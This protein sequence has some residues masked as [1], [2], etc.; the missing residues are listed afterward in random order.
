MDKGEKGV[1]QEELYNKLFKA[2]AH[3]LYKYLYYK[4]GEDNNPHDIVQEAF[5]KLW[6][7]CANV[8]PEKARA[9]LYTVANNQMINDLARKKTVLKYQNEDH[10]T[11]SNETPAYVMEE[12]EYRDQLKA[13][14]E[15]LSEDQRSTLMMHR[16]EGMKLREIAEILGISQK[17]VEKR[18]YTAIAHLKEKLGVFK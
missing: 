11:H 2:Y 14:L 3:E 13:A 17:A 15:S 4:Y 7:N 5:I 12:N 18:I 6:N 9:F 10:K 16:V 8:F 1:C